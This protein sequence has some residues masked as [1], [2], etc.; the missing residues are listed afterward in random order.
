MCGRD[1]NHVYYNGYMA[2]DA[3]SAS[4][5]SYPTAGH[6]GLSKDKHHVYHADFT[7]TSFPF[8]HPDQV[9]VPMKGADPASFELLSS[10]GSWAQ[11]ANNVYLWGKL[12]KTIDRASFQFLFDDEPQ[13][14]AKDRTH[15]YNANGKRTV[16]GVE[17]DSFVMLNPFWGKDKQSV[18]S[19]VTGSVQ[20]S[21]DTS[22]FQ[23]IDDTGGA[24]D[25]AYFYAIKNGTFKKTKK[26]GP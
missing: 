25:H 12:V 7:R 15:L 3:D 5:V 1:Q 18:F 10:T 17:G 16:K 13:S 6:H 20:K 2:G 11:D 21:A 8:G 26:K 19:F 22:T 23:V 4:F 9:L 14:W 24:E